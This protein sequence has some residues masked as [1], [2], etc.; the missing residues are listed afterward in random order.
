MCKAL[1]SIPSPHQ[2][3]KHQNLFGGIRDE[4][5]E[6]LRFIIFIRFHLSLNELIQ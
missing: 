1:G 4:G 6:D 5:W 2:Q 3:K